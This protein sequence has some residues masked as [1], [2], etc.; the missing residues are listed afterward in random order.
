[1]NNF[2][3]TVNKAQNHMP[4]DGLAICCNV[5]ELLADFTSEE[6]RLNENV[7]L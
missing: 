7:G 2:D 6:K 4:I 1:M 5:C 3:Q